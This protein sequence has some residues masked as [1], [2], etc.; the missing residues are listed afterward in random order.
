MN[1]ERRTSNNKD[2]IKT[3]EITRLYKRK[4]LTSKPTRSCKPSN[5]VD[6]QPHKS[7]N[8]HVKTQHFKLKPTSTFTTTK[9]IEKIE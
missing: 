3:I 1:D 5:T 7:I 2:R 4:F 8:L 9:N 6:H